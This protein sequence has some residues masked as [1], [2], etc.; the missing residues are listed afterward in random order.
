MAPC[1]AG[2]LQR[3]PARLSRAQYNNVLRAGCGI[4]FFVDFVDRICKGNRYPTTIHVLGAAIVKL[5][6]IT[7]PPRLVY[8]APGGALPDDF[9]KR[10]RN[11][12]IGIL[13]A[14]CL[15][16]SADK[17]EAMQCRVAATERASCACAH[18]TA[19][20]VDRCSRAVCHRQTR[21]ERMLR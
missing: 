12:T 8:R 5:G 20:D 18:S 13:E 21:S 10:S 3:P 1:C 19:A 7:G 4:S 6:K 2:V 11:G 9:Y 16:T 17:D 15:S 14:G